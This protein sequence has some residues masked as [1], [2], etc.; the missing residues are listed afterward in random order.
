MSELAKKIK[1]AQDLAEKYRDAPRA[2][3]IKLGSRARENQAIIVQRTEVVRLAESLARARH[4]SYTRLFEIM[5]LQ[6]YMSQL[7][8]GKPGAL[9]CK[10]H[11]KYF[12][13]GWTGGKCPYC[14][15]E[16]AA[17]D[18]VNEMLGGGAR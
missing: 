18:M 8:E 5:A 11:G 9:M 3:W 17:S 7:A 16:K 2:G 10:T 1:E 15:A 4:G 14:E 13:T 6:N 12:L